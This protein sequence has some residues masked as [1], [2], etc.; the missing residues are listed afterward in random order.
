M[1]GSRVCVLI[2][3]V[4]CG[5]SNRRLKLI[6]DAGNCFGWIKRGQDAQLAVVLLAEGSSCRKGPRLRGQKVEMS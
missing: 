6:N 1:R 3:L 2:L 5:E 4:C